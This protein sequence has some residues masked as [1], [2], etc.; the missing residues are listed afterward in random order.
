[1]PEDSVSLEPELPLASDV[2]E[3]P[4]K[5]EDPAEEELVL[6]VP[7]LPAPDMS[8]VLPEVVAPEFVDWADAAGPRVAKANALS[9]TRSRNLSVPFIFSSFAP[10]SQRR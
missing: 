1:M 5:P 9:A 6:P 7:A 8:V 3:V 4:D 10:D 2:P